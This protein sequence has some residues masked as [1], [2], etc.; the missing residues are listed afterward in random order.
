LGVGLKP[1]GIILVSFC[2]HLVLNVFLFPPKAGAFT[3]Q[4]HKNRQSA[5]TL[6]RFAYSIIPSILTPL[7]SEGRRENCFFLKILLNFTLT[8]G[9]AIKVWRTVNVEDRHPV[10][11]HTRGYFE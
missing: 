8:D 2:R 11:T 5:V 1:Q 6:R 4:V 9:L 7:T 3:G 10:F